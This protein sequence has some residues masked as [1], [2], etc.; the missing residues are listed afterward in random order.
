MCYIDSATEEFKEMLRLFK[1][2][3]MTQL[4]QVRRGE[5]L[6]L[7]T[8]FHEEISLTSKEIA[9]KAELTPPRVAAILLSLE[10]KDEIIRE[11]STTDRRKTFIKLSKTGR[12]RVASD[13]ERNVQKLNFAFEKMGEVHTKEF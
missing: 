9:D 2:G 1:K 10:A 12:S 11:M 6:V 5:N 8:L 7:R 3:M 13:I 4:E